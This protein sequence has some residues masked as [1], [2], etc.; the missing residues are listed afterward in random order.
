M[1]L[2]QF[3]NQSASIDPLLA[4]SARWVR[5][6]NGQLYAGTDYAPPYLIQLGSG[7][8]TSGAPTISTLPGGFTSRT[9]PPPPSPYAFVMFDLFPPAGPD[10]LYLADDGMNNISSGSMGSNTGGT[11]T[12]QGSLTKWT[13]SASTGWTQVTTWTLTAG[14]FGPDAGTNS[15]KP[16]GRRFSSHATR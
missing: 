13:F 4:V 9:S 10:T 7:L 1:Q 11:N 14:S 16:M 8:P 5:I 6:Y 15:N 3:P 2:A 12:G